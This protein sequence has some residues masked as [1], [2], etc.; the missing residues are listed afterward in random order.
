MMFLALT[1]VNPSSRPF[2]AEPNASNHLAWMNAI[3][4]LQRTLMAAE[5]TA[6]TLI[7]FGF[8]VAR[9]SSTSEQLHRRSSWFSGLISRAM[10]D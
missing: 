10:S 4:G 2:E 7:V 9:C 8:T 3:L 6:I 5:R 1:S